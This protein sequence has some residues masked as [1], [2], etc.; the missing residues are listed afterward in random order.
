M[1][2]AGT[3]PPVAEVE[4]VCLQIKELLGSPDAALRTA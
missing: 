3:A 4:K 1:F 2:E